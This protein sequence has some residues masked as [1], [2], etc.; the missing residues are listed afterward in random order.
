MEPVRR[1]LRPDGW[2][3][4]LG[5]PTVTDAVQW[6]EAGCFVTDETRGVI[7][8]KPGT[9][10]VMISLFRPVT[11]RTALDPGS[12]LIALRDGPTGRRGPGWKALPRIRS[13]E[14]HR[15]GPGAPQGI[16]GTV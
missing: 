6:A 4:M 16:S 9:A 3:A 14:S 13:F 15:S 2:L 5:I 8:G 10:E 12:E 7:P 11:A 1:L